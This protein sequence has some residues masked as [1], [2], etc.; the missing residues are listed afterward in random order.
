MVRLY[1][2]FGLFLTAATVCAD[3]LPAITPANF[4]QV[5][6]NYR[7]SSSATPLT[8]RVEEPITL[9][10]V[11]KGEGPANQQPERK[12]LRIFPADIADSF[13]VEPVPEQDKRVPHKRAPREGRWEFVYRMRP[14]NERV[15]VIP[16]LQL[17]FLP[18]GASACQSSFADEIPIRVTPRP[19]ATPE[20][21][22][23]KVVQAPPRFYALRPWAD[24]LRNDLP[25]PP[26]EPWVLGLLLALPPVLC[27]AGYRLW[28]RLNPSAAQRE[29]WR[30]SR[31]ARVAIAN[32]EKQ[33]GDV[34]R[35]R[36]VVVEFL[37]QRFELSPKEPTPAEVVRCLRRLGFGKGF[38]AGWQEFLEAC[39]RYQFAPAP[40]PANGSVPAEAARLIK[41]VEADACAR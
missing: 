40:V 31:A 8:V 24:V 20:T 4:S 21:L 3:D 11:V 1:L 34:A 36:A 15:K 23:L 5:V 39:D 6:G 7:I 22:A 32:L 28:R 29:F 18:K 26:P 33:N 13:H 25:A 14:K 35:T 10:V 19:E 41:A 38:V 30:R 27:F 9:T 17:V 2:F 16:E 12:N 37:R